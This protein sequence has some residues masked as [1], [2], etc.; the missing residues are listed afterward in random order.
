MKSLFAVLVIATLGSIAH[1]TEKATIQCVQSGEYK[2]STLEKRDPNMFGCEG[3][4]TGLNVCF[5]GDSSAALKILKGLNKD[6][7]LGDE[8]TMH[9]MRN[10]NNALKYDAF[11]EPDSEVTSSVVINRCPGAPDA[12]PQ[13]PAP[14]TSRDSKNSCADIAVDSVVLVRKHSANMDNV[15]VGLI[16]ED[17]DMAFFQ[18]KIENDN[19]ETLVKS[20]NCEPFQVRKNTKK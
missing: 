10:H 2:V 4:A 1:A 15:D 9:R 20:A 7:V 3:F 5:T 8:Y 14:T 12:Q 6:G 19:Y 16:N 18:I 11:S 13:P 17:E